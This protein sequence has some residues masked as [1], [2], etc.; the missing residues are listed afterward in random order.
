VGRGVGGV[1]LNFDSISGHRE[2]A[3]I[4]GHRENAGSCLRAP[5]P[6][7]PP[8]PLP[9]PCAPRNPCCAIPTAAIPALCP[10]GGTRPARHGWSSPLCSAPPPTWTSWHRPGAAPRWRRHPAGW[11][12]SRSAQRP[13]GTAGSRR[14]Q[15][16]GGGWPQGGVGVGGGG[17]DAMVG[18]AE[19]ET[20]RS[21]GQKAQ[22]PEGLYA[23]AG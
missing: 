2:N 15:G 11:G 13:S 14:Q 6:S 3:G 21:Q 4:S 23:E 17:P 9:G 7:P 22:Q 19:R 5:S 16:L 1:R 10:L 20:F 12:T 8:C 18:R